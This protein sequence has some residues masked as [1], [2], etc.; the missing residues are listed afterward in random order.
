MIFILFEYA[1]LD[2]IDR[3]LILLSGVACDHSKVRLTTE[4]SL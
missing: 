3:H 1:A 4:I 2:D